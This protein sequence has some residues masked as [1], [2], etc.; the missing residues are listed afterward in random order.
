MITLSKRSVSDSLKRIFFKKN[1]FKRKYSNQI[2][3]KV[4]SNNAFI[5]EEISLDNSL[6]KE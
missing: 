1:H 5:K 6:S 3:F 4:F 2:C